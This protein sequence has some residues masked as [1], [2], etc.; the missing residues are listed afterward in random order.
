MTINSTIRKA[1]PFIGN[2]TASSFPF[3]YKVFQA[4]DLDVVRLY[5]ST[6]VQTTLQLTTDYTVVLNQDQDSNPGGTVTLVAGPLATGYTLTMTSDVP[7]LQPTDLTN[8]G[9]FYPEVI[10]DALDRA[11]IQIQQLQEQ[12]D[13]TLRLPLSSTVDAE[14]PKPSPNDLIGWDAT[15]NALTNVHP[16]SLAS[17]VAYATAY[18]DVFVGNGI[19]TS[20]TLTRNPAVLYNLDVSINGSTQEPTRD[21]TLSGTT[22]TMTTPPPIGARVVVKY[23]EGLP[24]YEGDSQDVR[25]VPGGAGAVPRSVQDK[26]RETVSAT[27]YMTDTQKINVRTNSGTIDV[28][29]AIL[30]ARAQ[31]PSIYLPAGTY[32]V[33][34]FDIPA[35]TYIKTDGFATVIKRNPSVASGPAT[36][37]VIGSNVEIESFHYVGDIATGT[38]EWNH[39]IMVNSKSAT[40]AISNITLHDIYAENVRG[41]GA[42]FGA[43]SG[44]PLS[45]VRVG[46]VSGNNILRNAVSV[47][48][49][50]NLEIQS[51]TATNVGLFVFDIEPDQYNTPA[52]NVRVGVIQGKSAGVVPASVTAYAA[53]IQFGVVDLEPTI[54]GTN[55]TPAYASGGE[56]SWGLVLRNTKD[57]R[58]DSFKAKNFKWN[59]LWVV[60]NPGEL[61]V[62]DM[63]VGYIDVANCGFD[64]TV[65]NCYIW[66]NVI[67]RMRVGS[68]VA[69][70][71]ATANKAIFK[72]NPNL[73]VSNVK[74]TLGSGCVLAANV[75]NL[76]L[77]NAVVTGGT[78]AGNVSNGVVKNVQ[79]D[80]AE[81]AG[82]CGPMIFENVT[83]TC[84]GYIFN[85]PN[86]EH[87]LKNCTL[88]GSYYFEG[89][90]KRQYTSAFRMGT[91]WLWVDGAGK[92]RIKSATAPTTDLD[93]VVVGTQ[94]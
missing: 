34:P 54:Y 20:W 40:G 14:L 91:N 71:S 92:L 83:A 11:T 39:G 25:F 50:N 49:C 13:R 1:G 4:S 51:I 6:N 35:N 48:G 23:K 65:Y 47:C 32:M 15:G 58:V 55:S 36:I 70:A 64:E 52:T 18:C 41:D 28:T 67:Q 88:N 69:D 38:G 7:N 63:D 93:G 29:A 78:L 81:L 53:G 74:A 75:T 59:A 5:K 43:N 9:G 33:S 17:V 73:V 31:S 94:T 19:T 22:F 10:N 46:R 62:Q 89:F 30:A 44:Y 87:L 56:Q 68:V 27:D 26:E 84:S 82:Y 66:G 90:Y 72:G 80:G 77:D 85:S 76:V 8:Q 21:Y 24:N 37:N 79:I 45:N 12:T 3:T 57:I 86:D 60:S 2:G 61:G 42:Y 16:G